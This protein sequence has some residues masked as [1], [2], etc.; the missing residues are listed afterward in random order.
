MTPTGGK[1]VLDSLVMIR[2]PGVLHKALV[3]LAE[4]DNRPLSN[5]CR[6]VLEAHVAQA[7]GGRGR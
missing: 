2:M 4:K 1:K 5:Y 6:V 7:K 3:A